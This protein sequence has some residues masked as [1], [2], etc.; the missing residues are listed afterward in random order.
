VGFGRSRERGHP[1][2]EI[3]DGGSLLARV[4]SS[5][6][7][8]LPECMPPP[9]DDLPTLLGRGIEG[10][11]IARGTSVS[12]GEANCDEKCEQEGRER[13]LPVR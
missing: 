3:F 1:P 2:L 11:R 5:W 6:E 7:K 4:G 9:L 10:R 8:W 12:L 13:G